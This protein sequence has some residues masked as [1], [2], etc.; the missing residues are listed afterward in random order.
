MV[1][2][3]RTALSDKSV[4]AGTVLASWAKVDGLV[5]EAEAVAFLADKGGARARARADQKPRADTE[6]STENEPDAGEGPHMESDQDVVLATSSAA[7]EPLSSD[8][9]LYL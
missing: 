7:D 2:R 8:D 4:R 6:V 5:N 9:D 3:L 1:N